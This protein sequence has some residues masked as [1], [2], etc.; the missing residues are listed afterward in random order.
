MMASERTRR[1]V[2]TTCR[3]ALTEA[4]CDRCTGGAAADPANGVGR[5][6]LIAAAIKGPA[7]GDTLAPALFIVLLVGIVAVTIGVVKYGAGLPLE[8]W[9]CICGFFLAVVMMIFVPL[10]SL[11]FMP[12]YYGIRPLPLAVPGGTRLD[13]V[14]EGTAGTV[15]GQAL[16]LELA[17]GAIVLADA[18]T[19]GFTLRTDENDVVEVGAGRLRLELPADRSREVHR[20]FVRSW[21]A[22]TALRGR[23]FS[24]R[25]AR[26]IELRAG[27]RVA[28]WGTTGVAHGQ[29]R[30]YRSPAEVK[31]RVRGVPTI[32]DPRAP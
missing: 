1:Y 4:V 11:A 5:G 7:R 9:P 23:F 31:T 14:V 24:Y 22:A 6:A 19:G 15:V 8:K 13:G 17:D 3:T 25:R 32:R 21:L 27:D 20:S 2:C 28:I 26:L 18:Y 16:W 10:V 30:D 12:A 29:D